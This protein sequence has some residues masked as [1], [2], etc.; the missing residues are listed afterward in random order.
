MKIVP[1]TFTYTTRGRDTGGGTGP[2]ALVN[3]GLLRR[4]EQHGHQVSTPVD[5]TLTEE[6]EAGYGGWNLVATAGGRLAET[7][8]NIRRR[9]PGAFI[10]GLLADCNS[11]NGVLGG[12]QNAGG[13]GWPRRVGLVFVDAHG[14][15]NTPD[16]SPS[17]MLGGMP[18]A[19]A[20]GKALEDHRRRHGLRY[21]LQSPDIIMAGLRDLD[22]DEAR[23]IR[24]DGIRCIGEGEMVDPETA[25]Q[26]IMPQMVARQDEIYIHVD[27][28]VL[29]PEL[30]P[31]AGLPAPGGLSGM[32]LGSF[33]GVLL[34]YP[35]V[36]TLS[37]VSYRAHD[38]RDGRTGDEI[39]RAILTALKNVR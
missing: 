30:A 36:R 7:V 17:G 19:I 22:A 27:L 3:R 2:R 39:E 33:L 11:L 10:L 23:A 28:D 25:A 8:A 34:K 15:Y 14:D 9:E 29:D 16:T 4:L 37:V 24:E 35:G 6:E 38:D 20:A 18:V 32:Q 1:V 13:D 21:P 26:E 5:V 12:L 31:A